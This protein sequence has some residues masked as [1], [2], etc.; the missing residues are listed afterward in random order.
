MIILFKKGFSKFI[1]YKIQG[2]KKSNLKRFYI[3]FLL[4]FINVKNLPPQNFLRQQRN[5]PGGASGG[6]TAVLVPV[7]NILV[8]NDGKFR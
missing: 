4:I 2:N 3:F 7:V 6:T 8:E 5:L 1:L